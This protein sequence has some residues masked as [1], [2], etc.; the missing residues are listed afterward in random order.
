MRTG[1][2]PT[3]ERIAVFPGSFDPITRGHVHI[4]ERG[5]QLFDRII[6]GIGINTRKKCMF[7]LEERIRWVQRAFAH[8]TPRVEVHTYDTL[9]VTFCRQF[10]ARFILRGLRTLQDLDQERTMAHI[11][12]ELDSQIDTVILFSLPQYIHV[13]ST[14]VREVILRGGDF[15]AFVPEPVFPELREFLK[16]HSS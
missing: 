12:R 5:L 16:K 7:P 14:L 8:L 2:S 10:G 11:N 4:V 13:S 15:R 3:A 6:V 1:G 9:T